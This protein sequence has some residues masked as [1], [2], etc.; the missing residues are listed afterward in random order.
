MAK[1][2]ALAAATGAKNQ[3]TEF[4]GFSPSQAVLG[5]NEGLDHLQ[6]TDSDGTIDS[7]VKRA[8]RMRTT[9][10]TAASRA[11]ATRCG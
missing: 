11:C 8:L 5:K 4:E 2:E 10:M 6:P 7:V 1:K 3:T 9:A